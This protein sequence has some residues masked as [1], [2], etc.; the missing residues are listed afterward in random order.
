MWEHCSRNCWFCLYRER[1]LMKKLEE[2]KRKMG[3]TR[4]QGPDFRGIGLCFCGAGR[5]KRGR[6][7]GLAWHRKWLYMVFH[8]LNCLFQGYKM[9]A[10]DSLYWPFW[11]QSNEL[12][13]HHLTYDDLWC[14]IWGYSTRCKIS[15]LRSG[16]SSK[17]ATGSS[18]SSPNSSSNIQMA[19]VKLTSCIL[20]QHA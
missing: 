19:I 7:M 12:H 11:Q 13:Q 14:I 17:V 9:V 4:F 3:R 2:A 16:Y 1:D 18:W 20:L 8:Q 5:K 6:Q 15:H 10:L